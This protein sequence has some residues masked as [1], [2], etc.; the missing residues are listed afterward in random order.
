MPT[1]RSKKDK[2]P[3]L[4]KNVSIPPFQPGIRLNVYNSE[5]INALGGIEAFSKAI[6]NNQPIVI[7]DFG[8]TDQEWEQ[9][10]KDGV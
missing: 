5:Q 6:G 9:M 8:F 4:P 1:T 3:A 10:L 7:P 2:H